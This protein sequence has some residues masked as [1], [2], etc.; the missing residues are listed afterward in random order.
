MI[1]NRPRIF[2]LLSLQVWES[3][4]LC[5]HQEN[6]APAPIWI[7]SKAKRAE[8]RRQDTASQGRPHSERESSLEQDT[9]SY[10]I[11]VRDKERTTCK[12]HRKRKPQKKAPRLARGTKQRKKRPSHIGRAGLRENPLQHFRRNTRNRQPQVQQE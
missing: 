3:T 6:V 11:T 12:I 1:L 4:Y 2:V 8:K 5:L 7:G 9:A 10:T